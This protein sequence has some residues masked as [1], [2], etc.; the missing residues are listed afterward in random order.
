M[1]HKYTCTW[2]CFVVIVILRESLDHNGPFF[3]VTSLPPR[4]AMIPM[5]AKYPWW[6]W[7]TLAA[8][9]ARFMGPTWGPSGADRTQVGPMLAHELG[10]LGGTRSFIKRADI[11]PRHLVKSR[12]REIRVQNVKIVAEMPVKFQSDMVIVSSNLGFEISWYFTLIRLT[13]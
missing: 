2:L 4:T 8:L 7:V 12:S 1:C 5:P 3:T 10:C 9:I 13:A 11:L 6:I